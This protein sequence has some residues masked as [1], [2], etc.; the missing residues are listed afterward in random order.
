MLQFKQDN[1]DNPITAEYQLINNNESAIQQEPTTSTS[2]HVGRIND[3][4]SN[5]LNLFLQH[6][7]LNS[8]SS[9]DSDGKD[10]M[11]FFDNQLKID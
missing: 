10:I 9:A 1:A 6:K 3:Q 8:N 11:M 2:Q 5:D 4:N 7:Q